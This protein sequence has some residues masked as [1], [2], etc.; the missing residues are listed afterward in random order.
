MEGSGSSGFDVSRMSTAERLL[1]GGSILLLI[2]SFFP[3][4][5]Y[6]VG[7]LVGDLGGLEDLIGDRCESFNMWSL[8]GAWAGIIAG[9]LAIAV[10]VVSVLSMT[11][12][13]R[14]VKT[15][16][17]T[18]DQVVGSLGLGV[19]G[20]G[21]LKF[22]LVLTNEVAWGAFIGLLVLVAIGYG[23]WQKVQEGGGFQMG[24]SGTM[25]A[26]GDDAMGGGTPPP[27]APPPSASPP[28]DPP[29]GGMPP[30]GSSDM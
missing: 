3:W 21:L 1:A 23:A 17:M 24:G 27:S 29:S 6:C 2:V 15:G 28:S 20:F 26:S 9:L 10:V 18:P 5:T 4:Q 14:N 11:G 22:L 25:G 7:D 19:A 13:M 16:S 8:D 12:S 30:S